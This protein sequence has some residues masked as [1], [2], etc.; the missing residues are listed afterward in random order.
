MVNDLRDKHRLEGK[1]SDEV[2]EMLGPPDSP[3]AGPDDWVYSVGHGGY[4][5]SLL[6]TIALPHVLRLRWNAEGRV[7]RVD[8]HD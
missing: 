2:R 6:D 8:I 3:C 4:G 7:T 5:W 1:T